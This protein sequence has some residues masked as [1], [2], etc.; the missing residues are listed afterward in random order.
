M[1]T[2][3]AVA[4]LLAAMLITASASAAQKPANGSVPKYDK[5]TEAVFKGTVEDVKDRACP[6]SG[7]MGSHLMLKL[8]DGTTIVAT[9]TITQDVTLRN[10]Y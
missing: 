7:G 9:A 5:S 8:A 4:I 6:V 2:W 3:R 10:K 1:K